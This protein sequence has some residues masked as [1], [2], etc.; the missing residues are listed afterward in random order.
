M[1]GDLT[2]LTISILMLPRRGT[3][4]NILADLR[5][6]KVAVGQLRCTSTA[7]PIFLVQGMDCDVLRTQQ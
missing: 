6:G 3:C 1:T 2:F 5:D 4:D 7:D